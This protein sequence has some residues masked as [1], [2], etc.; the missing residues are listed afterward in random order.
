[1]D[2]SLQRQILIDS[3]SPSRIVVFPVEGGA[4]LTGRNGRGKTSLLQLIPVLYGESPNRLVGTEATDGSNTLNLVSF[5]QI[6]SS[7]AMARESA[8]SPSLPE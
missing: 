2:S 5:H 7:V 3:F 8:A 1:M 4:V 6:I